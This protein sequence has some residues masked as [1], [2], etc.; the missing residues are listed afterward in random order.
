MTLHKIDIRG[1]AGILILG[2]EKI[3][4]I[5]KK[6]SPYKPYIWFIQLSGEQYISTY[7]NFMEMELNHQREQE[8]FHLFKTISKE[9]EKDVQEKLRSQREQEYLKLKKEF[10]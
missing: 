1:I 3:L 7:P 10:E 8:I 2:Y 9:R 6:H 5:C 4:Y